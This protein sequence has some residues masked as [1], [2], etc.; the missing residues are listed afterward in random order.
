MDVAAIIINSK[1]DSELIFNKDLIENKPK[2]IIK[3]EKDTNKE[4]VVEKK[5]RFKEPEEIEE[6]KEIENKEETIEEKIEIKKPKKKKSR[7]STPISELMKE[8]VDN[9]K[10]TTEEEEINITLA[11]LQ[12]DAGSDLDLDSFEKDFFQN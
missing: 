11:D 1:M 3:R 9:K 12:S 10:E 7:K 8:K 6:L 5:V 4:D 2:P